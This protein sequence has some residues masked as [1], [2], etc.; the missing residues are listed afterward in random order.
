MKLRTTGRSIRLRLNQDDIRKFAQ[1]GVVEESITF[2]VSAGSKFVYRLNCSDQ[3]TLTSSIDN[4][5]ITIA[6]PKKEAQDWI[7]TEQVGIESICS[8]GTPEG[9]A[10]LIEKDFACL[11]PR[12][13]DD[14]IDSFP[15]PL[16]E[17]VS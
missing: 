5:V 12:T 3:S 8:N 6:I 16:A 9:L 1:T 2:G 17:K 15:H 11:T 7:E 4:G 10:V 14:D 13:G